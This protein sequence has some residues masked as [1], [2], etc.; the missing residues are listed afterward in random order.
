MSIPTVFKLWCWG[1]PNNHH[2]IDVWGLI[3]MPIYLIF[4][5][6]LLLQSCSYHQEQLTSPGF[7]AWLM[8]QEVRYLFVL[9]L[10][11]QPKVFPYLNNI[12]GHD[13]IFPDPFEFNEICNHFRWLYLTSGSRN[14]ARKC[15]YLIF[16]M[17]PDSLHICLWSICS[18]YKVGVTHGI[19]SNY[20][21]WFLCGRKLELCS[22]SCL[23]KF[24]Q[25]W[26]TC[27]FP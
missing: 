10:C 17:L 13:S 22:K 5:L 18:M 7:L 20:V 4:S 2:M 21:E 1:L 12:L 11:W 14:H 9:L 3:C 26:G 8:D 25:D 24:I 15:I 19:K 27:H 16:C 23:L 6:S